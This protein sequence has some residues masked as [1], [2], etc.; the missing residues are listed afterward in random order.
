MEDFKKKILSSCLRLER[1]CIQ[2]VNLHP[3]IHFYLIHPSIHSFVRSLVHS[4]IVLFFSAV[5]LALIL[6]IGATTTFLS[7][8]NLYLYH[9]DPQREIPNLLKS[10]T[11]KFL[12]KASGWRK[13]D[14]DPSKSANNQILPENDENGRTIVNKKQT[15]VSV[16]RT[17]SEEEPNG[18]FYSWVEIASMFDV[19]YFRLFVV[20]VLVV[21]VVFMITLPVTGYLRY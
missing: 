5:Y 8:I 7:V 16:V 10:F 11:T 21:T 15:N 1:T 3:F 2:I 12:C 19:F 17:L 9:Q 18:A 14:S 6:V 4:F 20:I 13:L